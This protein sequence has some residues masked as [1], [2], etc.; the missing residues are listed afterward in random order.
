MYVIG[1]DVGTSGIKSTVFDDKANVLDHAYREYNLICEEERY[2]ELNADFLFEKAL[3]VLAESTKNCKRSEVRAICVTSFGE[4]FICM[5]RQDKVL[6][7]TMIYMD[8]RG[9]EECMD[10]Q[11]LYS[12]SEIYQNSGQFVDPMFGMYK[13]KWL[14]KNKPEVLDRVHRISFVAD[15]ITYKLG[16]EHL[17]DYS[18]A[19]RSAMF[20]IR[21][22]RWWD[23]AVAF[24]GVQR[25]N[26]PKPVPSGS[27]VGTMSSKI[28]DLLGMGKDVKLV[29]GGHDQILAACGS[30]AIDTGDVTNGMGTVDCLTPVMD[31]RMLDMEKML[32]YKLPMT[33]YLA[34][35]TYVTYAFNMSGGS[36]LKWFRDA[37]AK[38]IA[39]LP[40]AYEILNKEMPDYPTNLLVV[41]YFGGG[42]T[43]D[44]DAM[45]PAVIAGMRL[46][47]T[48]GDMFRAFLESE[49]YEM[50][51][52]LTCIED[53]GVP[54][55]RII[56]VGGGS[57]S[58]EWM[59]IRANILEKKLFTAKNKEAGTLASAILCYINVGV[60]KDL[61][62]A[63]KNL[64][65]IENGFTPDRKNVSHYRGN[66]KRYKKLYQ[67]V[68]EVYRC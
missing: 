2:F 34:E 25:E 57:Q 43:P 15:F 56:A 9:V 32:A 55:R 41:P 61:R 36:I 28:A 16:A 66:F 10:F 46:N 63:Q 44:M 64:T 42:C 52:A 50:K 60:Y 14:R 12:E 48:R 5:D 58:R 21:T 62:E 17:C 27:V 37:L 38:D 59:Q 1:L 67:A 54:I 23:D 53:V 29:I 18:L 35:D 47:T 19:A 68:K 49:T 39:S 51:Q 65:Q 24:A 6:L 7:N 31:A 4:S 8:Q 40:D 45:T 11:A 22:K 20:D 26:L 30:G 33:P 13:M 3:E